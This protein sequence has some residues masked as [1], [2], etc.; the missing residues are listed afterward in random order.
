MPTTGEFLN[1]ENLHHKTGKIIINIMVTKIM[2][3]C[4]CNRSSERHIKDYQPFLITMDTPEN[5]DFEIIPPEPR[6]GDNV[7]IRGISSAES[8]EIAMTFTRTVPVKGGKYKCRMNDTEIPERPNH[9]T[10]RAENV[11][12]LKVRVKILLWMTRRARATDGVAQVC[13]S[14][15]PSGKYDIRI[16]GNAAE[17][18]SRVNLT[19]SASRTIKVENGRFEET[20]LTR[21]IPADEFE[22]TVAEQTEIIKLH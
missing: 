10:V 21:A 6:A 12:D 19:V 11:K 14:N 9:L 5:R 7:T 13:E 20:F 15:A 1:R 8:V 3:I 16:E 17:G 2:I 22:V 18:Q 4:F